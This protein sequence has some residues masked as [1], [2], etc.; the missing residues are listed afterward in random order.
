MA[1]EMFVKLTLLD[2]Y[3]FIDLGKVKHKTDFVAS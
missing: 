3:Y 2:K 1:A